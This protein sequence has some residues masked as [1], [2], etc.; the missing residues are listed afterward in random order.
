MPNI[1]GHLGL[2]LKADDQTQTMARELLRLVPSA[3]A[4]Y[5]PG[6]NLNLYHADLQNIPEAEIFKTMNN[7]R[8]MVGRTIELGKIFKSGETDLNWEAKLREDI[9]TAHI[10]A[11]Q[12]VKY[13]FPDKSILDAP[14]YSTLTPAEKENLRRYGYPFINQ[15]FKPY[16]TIARNPAGIRA[17]LSHVPHIGKIQKIIFARLSRAGDLEQ[18][19]YEI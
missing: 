4:E 10:H 18:V 19:L 14:L 12:L 7:I 13:C 6:F 17:S 15:Q 2:A 1:S 5:V 16:L 8:G 9:R 3:K 11:I